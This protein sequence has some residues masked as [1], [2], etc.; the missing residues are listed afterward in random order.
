[1]DCYPCGG[2]G[3]GCQNILCGETFDGDLVGRVAVSL[4]ERKP[5]PPSTREVLILEGRDGDGEF[6]TQEISGDPGW[7]NGDP[8]RESAF[9]GALFRRFF[10]RV[11]PGKRVLDPLFRAVCSY[12]ELSDEKSIS[13]L[14]RIRRGIDHYRAMGSSPI[15]MRIRLVNEF[16][17]IWPIAHHLLLS[18]EGW[19]NSGE[20]AA[21]VHKVSD[22]L[23][24][25][26]QEIDEILSGVT[27]GKASLSIP[28]NTKEV[29]VHGF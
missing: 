11:L 17:G 14:A 13:A 29:E 16:P 3:S 22:A 19:G 27:F 1:M 12:G 4:L 2:E 21:Y 9:S 24:I 25:L 20:K 28:S 10:L 6:N 15:E 18:G 7:K 5:L 23:S 8:E 26:S